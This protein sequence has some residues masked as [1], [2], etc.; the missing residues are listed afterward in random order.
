MAWMP[1]IKIVEL[2]FP[3]QVKVK[4]M[5]QKITVKLHNESPYLPTGVEWRPVLFR[6]RGGM[7]NAEG[8]GYSLSGKPRSHIGGWQFTAYSV[9]AEK[10]QYKI[11]AQAKLGTI[12]PEWTATDIR[13]F[14]I[15]YLP[16]RET[17]RK[18][19]DA[20]GDGIIDMRDIAMIQ[21]AFGS[22]FGAPNWNPACDL[23]G[24]GRVD[25]YDLGAASRNLGK[26]AV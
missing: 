3:S 24:D 2:T 6:Y 16:D 17:L 5:T 10:I 19:G 12:L 11:E 15:E 22:V 23:N 21:K 18:M 25:M 26:K 1:K 20:N 9:E 13:T 7:W 8:Y 14:T 4:D